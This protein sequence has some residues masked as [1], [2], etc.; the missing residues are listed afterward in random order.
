MVKLFTVRLSNP[1]A[2][3][4]MGFTLIPG[5]KTWRLQWL[6]LLTVL[7]LPGESLQKFDQED[8]FEK[9]MMIESVTDTL[10]HMFLRF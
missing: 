8:E 2:S 4:T 6:V 10:A 1:S 9:D 7:V 3:L 5:K